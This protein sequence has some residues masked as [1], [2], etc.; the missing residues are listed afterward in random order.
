MGFITSITFDTSLKIIDEVLR[1]VTLGAYFDLSSILIGFREATSAEPIVIAATV[2]KW[3][4]IVASV[5]GIMELV[6][7]KFDFP[8]LYRVVATAIVLVVIM[9]FVT[10][11]FETYDLVESRVAPFFTALADTN[12]QEYT[13]TLLTG[14]SIIGQAL[15]STK[16]VFGTV[17]SFIPTTVSVPTFEGGLT[18][19]EADISWVATIINLLIVGLAIYVLSR[20]S[21]TVA[22]VVGAILLM[23]AIG[24]GETT[25]G[26]LFVLLV[27]IAAIVILSKTR[28]R[29]FIVYPL[30]AIL[31]LSA[32]IVQPPT[33]VLVIILTAVTVML[34]YP[35]FYALAYLI[36]GAGEL[37]EKR[38]KL[39]MKRKPTKYVEEMAGEWDVTYT[40]F[41]MTMLFSAVLALYGP[42]MLGLGTFFTIFF[43]MVK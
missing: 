43:S 3:L 1:I 20:I 12:V 23:S 37:V 13:P 10:T 17:S 25:M 29:I 15:S 9:L 35:V 28:Y 33:N 21:Y 24:V 38:E 11:P 39:G 14:V 27:S 32:Y 36:Y 30:S 7:R 22:G 41:V 34:L 19:Q 42:T 4:L 26:V 18:T 40:A 8:L 16:V 2:F 5:Y 31:I 6:S